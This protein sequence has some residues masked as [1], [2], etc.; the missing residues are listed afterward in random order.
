MSNIKKTTPKK[1]QA[2]KAPEVKAPVVNETPVPV[3]PTPE[4]LVT[5]QAPAEP[6][7]VAVAETAQ[8]MYARLAAKKK[9]LAKGKPKMSWSDSENKQLRE[10]SHMILVEK[11]FSK[12]MY[13][14]DI[15]DKR[16]LKQSI[17][18]IDDN[19]S[20]SAIKNQLDVV[21]KQYEADVAAAK[22]AEDS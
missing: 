2:T 9:T 8:E 1:A 15:M 3:A 13:G 6:T 12:R 18:G 22:L 19:K 16:K 21:Y 17:A 5:T 14:E 20:A 11:L 7:P 10:I 4:P